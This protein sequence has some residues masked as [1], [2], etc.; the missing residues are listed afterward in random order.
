MKDD[1]DLK[2]KDGSE[3]ETEEDSEIE[4]KHDGEKVGD[5]ILTPRLHA[6]MESEI[7]RYAT[8]KITSNHVT[9]EYFLPTTN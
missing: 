2:M 8:S 7:L 5:M 3:S 9:G 4:T 1:D 6:T